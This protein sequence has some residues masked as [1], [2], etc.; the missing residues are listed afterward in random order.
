MIFDFLL[1]FLTRFEGQWCGKGVIVS[2]NCG[3]ITSEPV[4]NKVTI[5]KINEYTFNV[6]IRALERK[7]KS[8]ITL[9]GYLN[10]ET[11]ILE[12]ANNNSGVL[13]GQSQYYFHDRYLI[14]S[15]SVIDK[16]VLKSGTIKLHPYKK[17]CPPKPCPPKS[18]SSS[19]SSSSSCHKK[20]HKKNKK[21]KCCNK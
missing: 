1:N 7:N 19:S 20:K 11:G 10:K 9:L 18:S 21:H 17:P 2:N 4:L 14:N 3:R 12:L 16:G 8:I 6:T 5:R 13:N 15:F